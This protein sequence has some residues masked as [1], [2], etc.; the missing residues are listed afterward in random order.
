MK[1][2]FDL[3][4][5]NAVIDR[6]NNLETTTQPKWGKMSVDQMLAHC[7]VTYE[8]AYENI[9]PKPSGFKKALLKLFVKSIV[10]NEKPYKKN[11]RTAPE[12]LITDSKNF[13]IEKKRLIN[14]LNKTQNLGEAYF[15]NRESHSFGKLSKQEW[16]NM[17]YKHIDHHLNQFGV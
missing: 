17:F 14:Y 9:H 8:L 4:E 13:E 7:N 12:F 15:D 3:N 2:I 5:T 6:I 11:G 1:N 10:V 16:N